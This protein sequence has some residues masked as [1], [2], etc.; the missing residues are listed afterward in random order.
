MNGV[1]D[2]VSFFLD[3][4]PTELRSSKWL[5]NEGDG[6]FYVVN[7]LVEVSA[8]AVVTSVSKKVDWISFCVLKEFSLWTNDLFE[9]KKANLT[10]SDNFILLALFWDSPY[11][12]FDT[13][14]KLARTINKTIPPVLR[15]IA[16]LHNVRII[17][18][19]KALDGRGFSMSDAF[20]PWG[21]MGTLEIWKFPS[22]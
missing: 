11:Y 4:W 18:L 16:H 20:P 1:A 5:T 13:K 10:G 7:Q 6:F 17:D 19:F 21:C 14:N 22:D 2:R 12:V 9:L 15:Q 8:D 3:C